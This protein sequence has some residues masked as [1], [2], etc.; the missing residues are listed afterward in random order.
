[1]PILLPGWQH[2]ESKRP[3]TNSTS[4]MSQRLYSGETQVILPIWKLVSV[5]SSLFL[6]ASI[7]SLDKWNLYIITLTDFHWLVAVFEPIMEKWC[8][9]KHIKWKLDVESCRK[10]L[11]VENHSSKWYPC[12]MC[13]RKV[14]EIHVLESSYH[15]LDPHS[16]ISR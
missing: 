9:Q 13:P 12:I 1:M 6:S 14:S 16:L 11:K 15:R 2:W 10:L 7:E 4:L 5:R 8:G 3:Y